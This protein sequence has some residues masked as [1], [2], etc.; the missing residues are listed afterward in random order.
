[1]SVIDYHPNIKQKNKESQYIMPQQIKD[2]IKKVWW[3]KR[4]K[5]TAIKKKEKIKNILTKC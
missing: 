2:I 4:N 5:K 1:M 3:F